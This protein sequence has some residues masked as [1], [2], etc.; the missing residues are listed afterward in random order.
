MI[1]KRKEKSHK[2]RGKRKATSLEER[3]SHSRGRLCYMS[4]EGNR[5]G[6][7]PL[8]NTDGREKNLPQMNADRRGLSQI[9][10]RLTQIREQKGRSGGGKS[11]SLTNYCVGKARVFRPYEAAE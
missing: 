9:G 6:L 11:G 2:F 3:K 5:N 4:V 7:S 8:I 1:F 10:R